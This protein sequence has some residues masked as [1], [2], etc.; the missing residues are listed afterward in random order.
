[1]NIKKTT[2]LFAAV[3]TVWF[4]ETTQS[5]AQSPDNMVL[6]PAGTFQMGDVF[7]E[8]DPEERPLHTVFVSAFYMDKYEVTKALWDDVYQWAI[9]NGYNFDNPGFGKGAKHPVHSV[10]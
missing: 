9:A 5:G 6:I 3:M 8:G 1:M 7:N 10:N 2:A 4:G